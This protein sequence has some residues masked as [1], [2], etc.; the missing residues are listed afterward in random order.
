MKVSKEKLWKNKKVWSLYVQNKFYHVA[1]ML[2]NVSD[3]NLYKL[4][5]SRHY[6]KVVTTGEPAIVYAYQKGKS[7]PF[8]DG[9][10]TLEKI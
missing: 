8:R 5:S 9:S 2:K 3:C 6:L 10:A 7:P 4:I 1:I